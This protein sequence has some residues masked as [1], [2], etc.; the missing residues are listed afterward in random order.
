MSARIWVRLV[1]R[2]GADRIDGVGPDGELRARVR[3][4]PADGAANE[5]LRRLLADELRIAPSA[6]AIESGHAA[7]RKRV[8]LAAERALV[9]A[10]WPGL[11]AG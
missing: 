4:A 9:V 10:R 11:R 2:G 5:A 1:P 7:R 3:A 8:A 6:V